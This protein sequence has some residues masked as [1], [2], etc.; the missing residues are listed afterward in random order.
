MH[1]ESLGKSLVIWPG[2]L[3]FDPNFLNRLGGRFEAASN[4]VLFSDQTTRPNRNQSIFEGRVL[5][6]LC[7]VTWCT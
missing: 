2:A 1:L 3:Y 6:C 5:G 4:S 7:V